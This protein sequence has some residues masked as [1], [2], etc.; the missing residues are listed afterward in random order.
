MKERLIRDSGTVGQ[1]RTRML[2]VKT[3]EANSPGC[4]ISVLREYSN[5]EVLQK[6][7]EQEKISLT[8][9]KFNS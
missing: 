7:R 5:M 3:E 2:H 4:E 6:L 1:S 9:G 8:I